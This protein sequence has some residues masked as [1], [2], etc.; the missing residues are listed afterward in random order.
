MNN[1]VG[2]T[3]HG[4]E[5]KVAIATLI[6]VSY[7]LALSASTQVMSLVQTNAK[8][9]NQ[10][11]IKAI[12]VEVYWDSALTNKVTSIDWGT[13]DPGAKVNKTVYIKNVGNAASTLSMSTSNWNPSNA[14]TYMT[15]TWDYSG[16]TVN[17]GQSV[18]VK[19]TL[20]TSSSITGITSFSFD[21][22]I[23]STG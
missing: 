2:M 1:G 17:I 4:N 16:Q 3:A 9:S 6:L 7:V 12:G 5:T 19:F 21:L 20:T 14:A 23:T 11:S 13:I 22:T 10:G 18:Q 15:L 8:L